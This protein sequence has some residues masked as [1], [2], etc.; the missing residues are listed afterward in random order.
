[1]GKRVNLEALICVRY[2]WYERKG[3]DRE[4]LVTI[5][6]YCLEVSD[7]VDVSTRFVY[8]GKCLFI[9][10]GECVN[11]RATIKR[12]EAQ[13]KCVRLRNVVVVSRGIERKLI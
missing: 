9:R 12:I 10:E 6:R 4:R 1:V 5:H 11:L 7:T 2:S 3:W 13:Y 8:S